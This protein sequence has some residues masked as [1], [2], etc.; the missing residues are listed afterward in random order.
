[1]SDLVILPNDIAIWQGKPLRC[2]LGRGGRL[3]TAAKREGDGA[4]PIGAWPMRALLYRADRLAAP[5]IS[6][7]PA[8]ELTPNDGWCDAPLDPLYN[9]PVQH[10][11]P[12]SAEHLWLEDAAYDFIVPLGY[13]DSPIVAGSGSAIFL[14]CATPDYTPTAGCVALSHADMLLVLQSATAESF[15]HVLG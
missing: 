7:L 14:H 15:V 9:Q 2:A 6:P 8:R 12:A 11:Y 5:L 3:P 1:M 4:T 10:P 13:N